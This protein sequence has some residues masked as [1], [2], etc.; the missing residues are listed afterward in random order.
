MREIKFRAWDK[1]GSFVNSKIGKAEPHMI[2]NVGISVRE[3]FCTKQPEW[4]ADGGKLHVPSG[5]DEL[6][7]MQF[8]GFIDKDG[9]EIYEGDIILQD[10][11]G[12]AQRLI[13]YERGNPV[14]VREN[15]DPILL[16][17]IVET[18]KVIG[19]IYEGIADEQKAFD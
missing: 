14:A 5:C 7:L 1:Q 2:E 9:Q 17:Y 15:Y 19:N 10:G 11:P 18:V 12:S 13:V 4:F 16:S 6:V 8:T 3:N